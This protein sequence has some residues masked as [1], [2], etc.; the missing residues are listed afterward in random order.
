MCHGIFA[1]SSCD[2]LLRCEFSCVCRRLYDRNCVLNRSETMNAV[3]LVPRRYA[4]ARKRG[5][6]VDVLLLLLLWRQ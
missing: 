4:D 6:R 1:K 3:F 2:K 5:Q